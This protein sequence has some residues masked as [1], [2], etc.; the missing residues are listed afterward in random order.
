MA[1]QGPGAWVLL[2]SSSSWWSRGGC[3]VL[4]H[5]C[6]LPTAS[7]LAINLS[8]PLTV[9]SWMKAALLDLRLPSVPASC[10]LWPLSASSAASPWS[11]SGCPVTQARDALLS[12]VLSV[13]F[14]WRLFSERVGYNLHSSLASGCPEPEPVC[15][16]AR[17][18][19]HACVCVQPQPDLWGTAQL[20]VVAAW[21][22]L[23][24]HVAL[25]PS[26]LWGPPLGRAVFLVWW[27]D[28]YCGESRIYL[29]L[30]SSVLS[31]QQCPL[32]HH[33]LLT[34]SMRSM[35]SNNMLFMRY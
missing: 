31:K 1:F 23:C 8:E 34:P 26:H 15:V 9:K 6:P 19:V 33:L 22:A 5:H 11:P 28:I 29:V 21:Q 7:S 25:P 2:T 24:G 17:M 20:P 10:A 32:L 13:S 27:M 16:C 12:R 30:R 18:C 4:L 3:S 35:R 14:C